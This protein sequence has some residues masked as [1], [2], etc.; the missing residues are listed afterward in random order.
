MRV[1]IIEINKKFQRKKGKN[2]QSTT[3]LALKKL[4]QVNNNTIVVVAVVLIPAMMSDWG[5]LILR[6]FHFKMVLLHFC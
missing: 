2:Y 4:P 3:G 5:P 1:C 6:L